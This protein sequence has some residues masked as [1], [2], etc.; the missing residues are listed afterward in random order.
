MKKGRE[1]Y[2]YLLSLVLL[3]L[4][5]AGFAIYQLGDKRSQS[6][7]KASGENERT[8][9]DRMARA[10]A[11]NPPRIS[12]SKKEMQP[13]D[14]PEAVG[15]EGEIVEVIYEDGWQLVGERVRGVSLN[16]A[17]PYQVPARKIEDIPMFPCSD[18]HK[19]EK[20]NNRKRVLK[21]KHAELKLDHGGSRFWCDAC[22]D[23]KRMDVLVTIDR[24]PVDMDLGYL[25]CGQC[26]FREM[27]DWQ[28]GIHGKRIGFWAG[29]RVLRTCTECH[30]AHI[31]A[32]EQYAADPPPKPP[33]ARRPSVLHTEHRIELMKHLSAEKEQP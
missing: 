18:C 12:E 28:H 25:L 32:K 9:A 15:E 5:G 10:S 2:L 30:N 20:I 29:E 14:Q 17:R 33:K 1:K 7:A 23:G 6:P 8:L 24:K 19:G 11:A 16:G 31:P 13:W 21:E 27:D 26:H 4:L 3:L 22:H